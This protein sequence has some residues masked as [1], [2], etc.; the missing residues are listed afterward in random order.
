MGKESA[1]LQE[2]QETQVQSLDLKD[3][4]E[5]EMVAYSSVLAR[6]NLM[7]REPGWLQSMG[8]QRVRHD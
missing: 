8:L 1:S 2:T 7:D 4:L 3:P 6:E 5:E